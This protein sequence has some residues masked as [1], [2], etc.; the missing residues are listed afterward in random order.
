MEESHF[1]EIGTIIDKSK[2]TKSL[3]LYVPAYSKDSYVLNYPYKE[4]AKRYPKK[5]KISF[6]YF[7]FLSL[8]FIT[9]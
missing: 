7:L 9:K 1:S 8:F 4:G 3:D 6:L 5:Q 2:A